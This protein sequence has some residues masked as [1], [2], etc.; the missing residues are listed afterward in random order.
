[1][2]HLGAAAA[3]GGAALGL[4][5]FLAVG[6]EVAPAPGFLQDSVALDQLVKAP[7]QTLRVFAVALGDLQQ[8]R[9]PAGKS[10]ACL[11]GPA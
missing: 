1:M 7:D 10:R 11:G 9:A 5:L 2:R 8:K 6:D 4:S 3:A